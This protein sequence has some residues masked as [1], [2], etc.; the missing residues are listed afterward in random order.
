[1]PR[2]FGPLPDFFHITTVMDHPHTAGGQAH[3]SDERS[4]YTFRYR[5]FTVAKRPS[6]V[7][8]PAS[9]PPGVCDR[10]WVP[11]N[12]NVYAFNFCHTRRYGNQQV[13]SEA[14]GEHVT[15][16]FLSQQRD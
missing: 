3:L 2:R 7:S 12:R 9:T 1:V 15:G 13:I 14:E 5:D 8:Q 11:H 16:R 6:Q 10:N 4:G